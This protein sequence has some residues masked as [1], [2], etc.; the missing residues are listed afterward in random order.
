MAQQGVRT[1]PPTA[2][3][4]AV[5]PAAG[6]IAQADELYKHREDMAS[7]KRAVDLYAQA[8]ATSFDAAWKLSRACYWIATA[9]PDKDRGNA[10]EQGVKAGELAVKLDGA[11]PEGHFW[12]AANLGEVADHKFALFALSYPGRI[13]KELERVFDIDR[14]WQDGSADR[15]LGEW[16][17]RVPGVAGGDHKLAEEHLRASLT[18]NAK[19]IASLFFLAEVIADDSKRREEAKPLLQQVLAAPL[20]PDWGPE[21]RD[22]QAKAKALLAKITR[23]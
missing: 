7:A 14:A 6:P 15:A 1:A 12:L 21:D 11:K 23:K 5:A 3:A 10:R 8:A 13:K 4:A 22:F 19:S 9:G 18:Y 16:Y 2:A 17:F 20:D